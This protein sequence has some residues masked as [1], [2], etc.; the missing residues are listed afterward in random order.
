MF[1]MVAWVPEPEYRLLVKQLNIG[2]PPAGD[3]RFT[4]VLGIGAF[5]FITSTTWNLHWSGPP[6]LARAVAEGGELH[7][8]FQGL[9]HVQFGKPI[10]GDMSKLT[11]LDGLVR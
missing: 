9:T 1:V 6:I 11:M 7:A 4:S 10:K 2:N 5:P 8:A 3:V